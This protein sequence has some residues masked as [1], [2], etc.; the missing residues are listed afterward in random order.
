MSEVK[1]TQAVLGVPEGGWGR[2]ARNRGGGG[3]PES[4]QFWANESERERTDESPVRPLQ[5][6]K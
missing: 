5:S 3:Q 2:E 4:D 6:L 1:N